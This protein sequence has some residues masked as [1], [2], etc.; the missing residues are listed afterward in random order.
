MSAGATL[1]TSVRGTVFASEY[2]PSTIKLS[3][4]ISSKALRAFYD[5]GHYSLRGDRPTFNMAEGLL[6]IWQ[7]LC[8]S[9]QVKSCLLLLNSGNM[10]SARP[11]LWS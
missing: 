10:C 5:R 3:R 1:N 8:I 7:H 11:P 9:R 4:L 2:C 6:S